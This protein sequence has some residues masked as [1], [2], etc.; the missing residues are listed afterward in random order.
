MVPRVVDHTHDAMII[1]DM[2]GKIVFANDRFQ[3]FGVPSGR[4][5]DRRRHQHRPGIPPGTPCPARRA[6]ARRART[7]PFRVRGAG[8]RWPPHPGG[9]CRVHY[10]SGRPITHTQS[11]IHDITRQTSRRSV[12]TGLSPSN[13][14]YRPVTMSDRPSP[15]TFTMNWPSN[16]RGPSCSFRPSMT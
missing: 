7:D 16:W 12:A 13:T 11:T 15:T 1:D 2:A 9:G 5:A 10:R 6:H 8:P 3:A 4:F 14:C